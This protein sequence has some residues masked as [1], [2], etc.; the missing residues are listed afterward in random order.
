MTVEMKPVRVDKWLWAARFFKTRALASEAVKAG[1]VEINAL[2]C[3]PSK[4][5]Q[6]G[7]VLQIRRGLDTYEIKVLAVAEKRA[8]A[9]LAQGLYVEFEASIQKRE[10]AFQQRKMYAASA[11]APDK[12]PDKKARRNIIRFKGNR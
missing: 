3:K 1:H 4:S 2:R 10:K 11:P 7:D 5:V 9:K 12:R 6:L 8:S